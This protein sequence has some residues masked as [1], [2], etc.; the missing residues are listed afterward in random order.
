M[1]ITIVNEFMSDNESDQIIKF[2]DDNL[3]MFYTGKYKLTHRL[4]YGIDLYHGN[5]NPKLEKID[6]IEDIVLEYF[7]K[8]IEYIKDVKNESDDLYI[9]SFWLARQIEGGFLDLHSDTDVDQNVQ[10]EYSCGIYLNDVNVDGTLDFPKLNYS[11][12]PRKGDMVYWPS[13]DP[14]YDHEVSKVTDTRYTML[15]WL[16]KDP[17]FNLL[18]EQNV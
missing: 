1:E 14:L 16:T 4:L 15:V 13:K 12:K 5:S 11:Y 3:D 17:A 7:N 10:F 9:S 18:G 6:A 8:V 2:I